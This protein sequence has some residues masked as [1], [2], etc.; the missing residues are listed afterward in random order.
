MTA[1]APY[2]PDETAASAPRERSRY[3]GP[4]R[5]AA[6]TADA[7]RAVAALWGAP[8]EREFSFLY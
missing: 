2:P 7:R 8:A 6:A 4:P 5:S 3:A 1:H